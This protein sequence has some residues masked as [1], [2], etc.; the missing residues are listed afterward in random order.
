MGRC[1]VAISFWLLAVSCTHTSEDK[2]CGGFAGLKCQEGYICHYK[3][4]DIA[5]SFGACIKPN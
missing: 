4:P 5:D 3:T 2:M 1:I